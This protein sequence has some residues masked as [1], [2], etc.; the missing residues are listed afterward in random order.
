MTK[1][2]IQISDL[3]TSVV[4]ATGIP[5][6]SIIVGNGSNGVNNL[7]VGSSAQQIVVKSDNT[8]GYVNDEVNV[9][10]WGAKG[11]GSTDDTTAINNAVAQVNTNG[12]GVLRFPK[13]SGAYRTNGGHV[14]TSPA[15]V[16]GDGLGVHIQARPNATADILTF[17]SA[18]CG[19][20]K[21]TLDGNNA[22]A[23]T[24]DLIVFNSAYQWADRIS[25]I[26]AGA[27]GI[28]VGK[29][30]AAL[31]PQIS[32]FT[33]QASASYGI[34]IFSG[35][36]TDGQWGQGVVGQS[37]K[38]GFVIA[39]SSQQ[40]TNVHVW[41]SGCQN[42]TDRDGFY[43]TASTNHFTNCESETNQGQG[44]NVT[45]ASCIGN[46]IVGGSSWGNGGNGVQTSGAANNGSIAGVD[47]YN[48][49]T[50]NIGTTG[51]AFAGIQNGSSN[52]S[53]IGSN[54]YDNGNAISA[55]SYSF[56]ASNPY[57]G[58]STG[59]TQTYHY[60]EVS[61]A[62]YNIL[63]GNAMRSEQ[64]YSGVPL[65]IVGSHTVSI[66]N[67][68]GAA[69][70]PITPGSAGSVF[71]PSRWYPQIGATGTALTSV[72]NTSYATSFGISAGHTFAAIG[73]Y[74]T[75]AGGTGSTARF[76]VYTDNGAAYPATLV[77]DFGT[78]ATTTTGVAAITSSLTLAPALYWLIVTP[79]SGTSPAF[80]TASTTTVPSPISG[81]IG[82]G[83]AGGASTA[84]GYVATNAV[85]GA[86]PTNFPSGAT[87]TSLGT[88]PIVQLEG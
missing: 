49:G 47:I 75:A 83:S 11:D 37:G 72:L 64:S 81:I 33:I 25:L 20:E 61:P 1:R 22:N 67:Q 84:A 3:P 5:A 40:I 2:N 71:V 16:R 82:S 55:A 53:I 69:T 70:P 7:P 21:L 14:F 12:G 19:I 44:W 56:T 35:S 48:N 85:S 6:Q 8:L 42:T 54:C 4:N 18:Y 87:V 13:S 38:S 52:W 80:Q 43:V 26:N 58:R 78:I 36:S 62:D 73:A 59:R 86:M 77:Q 29:A 34:Q 23:T 65:L 10:A 68:L 32:N 88:I 41:G 28:S 31:Q 50:H 17:N 30:S 46:N 63:T 27:N 45:G 15:V 51:I 60:G 24:G 76:A 57:V 74:V 79:Q 66:P 39:A 9:M